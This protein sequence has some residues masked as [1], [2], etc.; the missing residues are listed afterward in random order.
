[1]RRRL[2]LAQA[3]LGDPQILIVDEPTT[4]LDP[5]EQQRFRVLP[6]TLG[7]QK[8]RTILLSTHIVADLAVSANRLAVLEKGVLIFDGQANELTE[9]AR[10]T[11]WLWR[12]PLM[13][14]EHHHKSRPKS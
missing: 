2:G 5:V 1:M 8:N 7:A 14:I 6:G 4:G 3:L 11:T 13:E 9:R 12:A 10:G